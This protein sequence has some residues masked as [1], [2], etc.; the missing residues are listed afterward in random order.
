MLL[1]RGLDSPIIAPMRPVQLPSLLCCAL[2]C[3]AVTAVGDAAPGKTTGG[4]LRLLFGGDVLLGGRMTAQL[5][6]HGAAYPSAQVQPILAEADLI[7]GN[8]ECPLTRA[9][10]VTLGKD[11]EKLATGLDFVF[12]ADP[13]LGG[14]ALQAAGFTVMSVANN[15]AMDYRAAGLLET[16]KTL[17]QRNIVAAGGGATW[18]A[19][20]APRILTIRGQRIGVLAC[21][22][23][24]PVNSGAG[25]TTPGIYA[26]GK[27]WN[28]FLQEQVETLRR[29]CDLLIFSIHWGVEST[30]LTEPYQEAVA[31]AALAAGADLVIGHHPHVLQPF[32]RRGEQ[33]IAYSLGNFIFPGKSPVLP[34]ALLEVSWDPAA[35]TLE[36]LLYP[37]VLKDGVPEPTADATIRRTIATLAPGLPL[38]PVPVQSP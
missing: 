13:Q 7:F 9:T 29:K 30:P 5:Q 8:L 35:R 1:V 32:E 24:N 34:S 33:L 19:A 2:L 27:H 12:K 15:H 36:P 17:E 38:A 16:L 4:P 6:R 28:P 20:V 18:H 31:T 37:L 22:M 11:P 14:A 21:S 25:E 26:V 10:E 3:L 23:I